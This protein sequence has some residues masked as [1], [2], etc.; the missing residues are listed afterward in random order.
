[1][2]SLALAL[3]AAVRRRR[4]DLALLKALGFT[5]RQVSATIAWQATT[6][7]AVGLVV[8]VPLGIVLGRLMWKLFARQLDVVAEPAV[9]ILTIA[10]IMVAAVIAANA[11]AVLPARYARA[12]P[13]ALALRD[14]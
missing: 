8:G 3:T 10:V 13:A 12:V 5:R 11:L 1:L 2:A 6:T 7:I 4:R 9:P 14:E